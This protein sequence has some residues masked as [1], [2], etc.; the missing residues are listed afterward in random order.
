M[1]ASSALALYDY[2][3]GKRVKFTDWQEI[4]FKSFEGKP[5]QMNLTAKQEEKVHE[6]YESKTR[7]LEA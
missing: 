6:I 3:K 5:S 1:T 4:F 2:L 7:N